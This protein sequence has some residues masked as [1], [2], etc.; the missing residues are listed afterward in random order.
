MLGECLEVFGSYTEEERE[1]LILD[2]YIPKPGSYILVGKNGEVISATDFKLDKKTGEINKSAV[3]FN[4]FCYYDYY[5]NLISMNKPQDPDK[6]I[7]SNNYLSFWIKKESVSNGKL[8]PEIIDGY[9]DILEHPETKCKK[10]KALSIYEKLESEIGQVNMEVL[11]K[12]KKWIQEHIFDMDNLGL[13]I[14]MDK[15]DYLKIFLKLKGKSI[16]EKGSVIL[17]LIFIIATNITLL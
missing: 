17:F 12:N 1:Q 2:H 14:D 6:I 11:Q 16:K 9:Y 7:H 3:N 8:T 15:K 13:D 10:T 5:S 4:K